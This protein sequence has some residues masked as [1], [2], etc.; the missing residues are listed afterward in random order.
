MFNDEG[1]GIYGMFGEAISYQ[2]KLFITTLY[3]FFAEIHFL[4]YVAVAVAVLLYL[5]ARADIIA[6]AE[7]STDKSQTD[8][9]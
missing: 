2:V 6:I 9:R 7:T 1:T 4:A 5:L 3:G 8:V